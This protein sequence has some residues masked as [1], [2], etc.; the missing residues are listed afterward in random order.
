MNGGEKRGVERGLAN[1]SPYIR[2]H[3]LQLFVF[4]L[5]FQMHFPGQESLGKSFK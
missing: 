2:Q 3:V 4:A 1:V 5:F